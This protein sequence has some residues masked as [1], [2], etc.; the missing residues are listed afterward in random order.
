[1][2]A[3]ISIRVSAAARRAAVVHKGTDMAGYFLEYNIEPLGKTGAKYAAAYD[4]V[5]WL[6]NR[7]LKGFV[8]EVERPVREYQWEVMSRGAQQELLGRR[9]YNRSSFTYFFP[10]YAGTSWCAADLTRHW[11]ELALALWESEHEG[12]VKREGVRWLSPLPQIADVVRA[13]RWVQFG[14]ATWQMEGSEGALEV[15][16]QTAQGVETLPLDT[17]EPDDQQIV[18]DADRSGLCHCAACSLI[19]PHPSGVRRIEEALQSPVDFNASGRIG[20]WIASLTFPTPDVLR[21]L[22]RLTPCLEP[23]N[24]AYPLGYQ[25]SPLS[26]FYLLGKRIPDAATTLH[27]GLDSDQPLTRA[28]ALSSLRGAVEGQHLAPDD[29]MWRAVETLLQGELPEAVAAAEL[30]DATTPQ[31]KDKW[32]ALL[33]GAVM[34]RQ[35]KGYPGA[36]VAHHT[37]RAWKRWYPDY[38]EGLPAPF[39]DVCQRYIEAN[40]RSWGGLVAYELLDLPLP[41]GI[42]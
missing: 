31:N 4:Y 18:R 26:A 27:E 1:M 6:T 32:A 34:Q 8:G 2:G 23:N 24:Y 37:F 29:R 20:W 35:E 17:L 30:L 7:M 10:E 42:G 3:G 40:P 19:V 41:K 38:P 14:G 22:L 21:S 33:A 12:Y 5:W 9:P 25:F 11:M 36:V 28:V 39:R 13:G 16:R 15:S